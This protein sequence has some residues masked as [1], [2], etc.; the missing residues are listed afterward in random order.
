MRVSRDQHLERTLL[1]KL[2]LFQQTTP[3]P[4]IANQPEQSAFIRQLV[5]SIRRIKYV[6]V[7]RD[8]VNSISCIDPTLD[9]FNPIKAAA[10]HRSNGN[11]EEACWLVFLLTHFGKNKYSGWQLVKDVYG[12]MEQGVFDWHQ[13]VNNPQALG[14]WIDQQQ[15]TLKARGGNFGNHRKY[16]SLDNNHTGRTISSYIEWIGPANLHSVKFLQLEPDNANPKLRFNTFYK[17]MKYVHGFGRTAIFDYLTMLGKLNLVDVEPD[18]V[19][20]IGATGPFDGGNLLFTGNKEGHLSR[21]QLNDLLATL[22]RQ[23]NI[24]FGMQILEDAICNWQKNPA[25]YV[26]FNG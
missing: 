2:N 25:R 4:G 26:Y 14:V 17:N 15:T 18:S 9:G 6:T 13:A 10:F 3:L 23:L 16:Q 21:I 7:I 19:Y 24:P 1:D 5:D 11:S 12:Q 8:K 20:M 22:D